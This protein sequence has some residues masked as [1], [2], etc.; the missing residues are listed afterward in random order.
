MSYKTKKEIRKYNS[1][2]TIRL[3]IFSR[4]SN[5]NGRDRTGPWERQ[6]LE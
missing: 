3:I 2:V 4:L 5:E 1:R 6:T